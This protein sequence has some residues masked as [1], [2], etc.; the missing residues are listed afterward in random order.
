MNRGG[1]ALAA[2]RSVVMKD[3]ESAEASFNLGRLLSG[4]RLYEEAVVYFDRA[5]TLRPNLAAGW[6]HRG[7][8]LVRLRKPAE[9]VRSFEQALV[10]G[11]SSIEVYKV[12]GEVL[13]QMG[14]RDR[15]F[16]W[17]RHGAS[18][19]P[20]PGLLIEMIE[21]YSRNLKEKR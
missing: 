20:N 18:V 1:E 5:L 13:F 11:P 2:A 10:F 4:G 16:R 21:T 9:A 7:N 6:Y 15:A 19:V 8:A 12:V 17:L 14:E 3:P